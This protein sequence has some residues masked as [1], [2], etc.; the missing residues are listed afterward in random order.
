MSATNESFDLK[1]DRH[2]ITITNP[3]RILFP[4]D[5]LTKLDLI[6]YYQAIAPIM[7]PHMH[8]R[9]V[10][11]QRFPEGINHEGFYQKDAGDYFPTWIKREEME[12]EE[13]SKTVHYVV[14]NNAATLVYLAQQAV[15][16]PHLWLSTTKKLNYPDRMIFD[17]DPPSEH[18]F[19]QVMRAAKAMRTLLEEQGLVPH[20]MTTGSKGLH[21]TTAIKPQHTFDVMRAT[22][23][24]L[25]QELVSRYPDL[26]TTNVRKDAR[27]GK[28]FVDYLRNAWGQTGVA[29]YAVRARN[30][31][32]IATPLHWDELTARMQAQKFTMQNIFKRLARMDDPWKDMHKSARA[33]KI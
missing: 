18:A 9:P 2:T 11:M 32:P 26:V 13:G 3:D 6:T 5:K 19:A 29:P 15:I 24:A 17:F 33:L 16:T 12:T 1:I 23:R 31:A 10:S 20:V 22:A 8:G 7:I 30:G 28:V 27:E 21:V 14:C 4:Q 25:A